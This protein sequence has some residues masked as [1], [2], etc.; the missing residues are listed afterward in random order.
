MTAFREMG[1]EDLSVAHRVEVNAFTGTARVAIP[2]TV[3]PGRE[4]FGPS[5]ELAYESGGASSPFG[6]GWTLGGVPAIGIDTRRRLPTYDGEDGYAFAGEPLVPYLREVG[7]AWRAEAE[8][9]GAY[10]V[11]RFR[12]RV[13][14]TFERFERWTERGSGRVHWRAR[15][16]DGVVSVFGLAEDGSTRIADPADPDRRVYQWL[17]EAQHDRLGNRIL[18]RYKPED[19]AGVDRALAYEARRSG[20]GLLPQRYLKAISYVNARP[21]A[22]GAAPD[23]TDVFRVEVVL[24]YGEHGAAGAPPS[25]AEARPWPVRADPYTVCTPGFELRSW[26]LCRRILVF[27]R[28]PELGPEPCLVAATELGHRED[29]AGAVL[30]SVVLRG[31]RKDLDSGA[32]DDRAL[33]PLSLSYSGAPPAA[34]FET[35]AP[36]RDPA[37]ALDGAA[38]RLVDL[39]GEG[40]PGILTRTGG[41]WYYRE[42]LGDGRFGPVEHAGEVPAAFSEAFGLADFDGDGNLD[43]VAFEGREAGFYARDRATGRWLGFRAFE[44]LPRVDLGSGRAQWVD[45]NGDGHADLVVDEGDRL[46]WYASEGADGFRPARALAKPDA[47]AGGAPA[48]TADAALGLLFADMNGDGLADLVRVEDGRIEYWPSLGGGRFGPGVLMEDAPLLGGFGRL[49]PTRVRLV[50][51]DGSGTAD[52]V[53]LGAG[54]V[55]WWTNESGNRFG[56]EHR[57]TGLPYLDGLSSAQ[58]VDLMGD[59]TLCLVWSSSLPG[60]V[61]SSYLRLGGPLPPRLLVSVSNGEGRRTNLAYRSSARDLLRDKAAGRGWH[62]LLPGHPTVVAALEAA[63]ELGGARLVTTYAYHDGVHDDRER[64]MTGFGLVERT[65]GDAPLD[66]GP[67]PA[68]RSPGSL[69]RTWFLTG[70]GDPRAARAREHWAGDPLAPHL[71]PPALEDLALL[72]A[73]EALEAEATLAASL[74]REEVYAVGTD[75][76]RAATPLTT[77]EATYG[78]R[79]LQ[80]ASGGRPAVFTHFQTESLSCEY[81][82]DPADPRV[83]HE[84]LLASS[85]YGDVE[86][87]VSI[88]YGRRAHGAEVR[89]EQRVL[90]AT[91]ADVRF[92][93]VDDADRYETGIEVDLR[94]HALRGLTPGA[95]GLLAREALR[96]EVTA[97]LAAPLGL[98]EVDP[99]GAPRARLVSWTRNVFWDAARA[100]PLPLGEVGPVTLLHHVERAVLADAEVAAAWGGRVDAALLV[101]GG[102]RLDGGTWWA[103]DAVKHHADGT[104]FFRLEEETTA[105]GGRQRFVFDDHALLVR[106]MEDAAGNQ[107]ESVLDYQVLA[108]TSVTDPNGNV[109]EVRYDPLGVAIVTATRGRQLGADDLEHPVG[110]QA[111]ATWALP[112]GATA[113]DVLADP[114][115]FLQAASTFRLDDVHAFARGEGPPRSILLERED[116]LDDGEGGA[117]RTASRIRVTVLYADGLGRTLQTK[118]RVD[119]G[120]AI[121][122][123]AAGAVALDAAGLPALAPAADRW[124]ASGHPVHDQRGWVVRSFEPFFTTTPAFEPD[125]ALRAFGVSARHTFDSAGR[126]V[127]HDL[128]DGTV[129]TI[130]YGPWRTVHS[131]ANDAVAGSAWEAARAALPAADPERRAL[132]GALAH[133]GTPVV[134][135]LDPRGRPIRVRELGA[136]GVERIT[137][138]EFGDQGL[139]VRAVDARG[140]DA[141][142][143]RHDMLGRVLLERGID[144]GERWVLADAAGSAVHVWDARGVHTRVSHDVAGRPLE[145]I[146]EEPGL[147]PRVVVR[148]AYGDGPGAPADAALRNARGRP[149]RVDDEAGVRYV[150]RY[151]LSGAE[152]DVRR[153]LRTEWTPVDWGAP[154]AVTLEAA[155]HRARTEHDGLGRIVRERLADGTTRAYRHA[156]AGHVAEVRVSTADGLLADVLLASEITT[157]A[158]GRRT[159]LLAGNGV[160]TSYAYD[161]RSAR[162]ARLRARRAAGPGPDLADVVYTYDPVGNVT[163][164]L[165]RAHD[166]AAPAPL[167]AGL[168][169]SAAC[170]YTYD[171]FYQLAT[172]TGRVHQA[173]LPADER[174]PGAP[175]SIKGTRHLTLANGAAIERYTRTYTYDLAG[176][177]RRIRHDGASRSWITEVWT[178]PTSNRSLPAEGA[179]G[180]AIPDPAAWFDA[181]GHV[182]RMPH[183]RALRWDH[184]GRLVGATIVDRS[185]AGGPDDA[186]TYVHDADGRRVRRITERLVAGEVERTDTVYL[187]GCELRR[188]TRAGNTRLLRFTSHL[189]DGASRLATLHQWSVDLGADDTADPAQ[190]RLVYLVGN[191]LGSTAL[192]LDGAGGVVTYEEYFP[193]GGTSFVAGDDLRDVRRKEYRHCGRLRDDATGFY[194]Y[195]FRDYAPWIGHW[196][197][198]DPL[199]PEDGLNLYAFVQGNPIRFVDADGLQARDAVGMKFDLPEKYVKL[200]RDPDPAAGRALEKAVEARLWDVPGYGRFALHGTIA[201]RKDVKEWWYTIES[202]TRVEVVDFEDEAV[203]PIVERPAGR[204]KTRTKKKKGAADDAAKER[205]AGTKADA[206]D[207]KKGTAHPADGSSGVGTTAAGATGESGS[208]GTATTGTAGGAGAKGAAAGGAGA[209][210]ASGTADLPEKTDPTKTGA[211]AAGGGRG[212]D[213]KGTDED[214]E[215]ETGKTEAAGDE[216]GA[217]GGHEKGGVGGV[218]GG[219]VGGVPNAPP[220]PPGY[221]TGANGVPWSPDL[222]PPDA[223]PQHGVPISDPRLLGGKDDRGAPGTDAPGVVRAGAKRGV[224]SP[225]GAGEQP[226]GGEGKGSGQKETALGTLTRLAGYLNFSKPGDDGVADGIPGGL[227]LLGLRGKA[228]QVLYVINT[229]VTTVLSIWS[230]V[231]SVS[232]SALRAGFTR[233]LTMIRNPGAALR[234]LWTAMRAFGGEARGAFSR[235]VTSFRDMRFMRPT[236]FLKQ[237]FRGA[238]NW[239]TTQAWRDHVSFL[240]KPRWFGKGP[241]YNWEHAVPQVLGRNSPRLAAA[242]NGYWNTFLRLPSSFNSSLGARLAP[243]VAF[244]VGA[245]EA[246]IRSFK[247]GWGIGEDATTLPEDEP[248]PAAAP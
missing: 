221:Q 101:D 149:V 189:G 228:I 90:D 163:R 210:E 16:G 218:A 87:Q 74:W 192:E 176:N 97:A 209:S 201:W 107:V 109:S 30:A 179:D 234:G 199:G 46:V 78:V 114:A 23:P 60:S 124:L 93:A 116:H 164:I 156:A 26:R 55:R 153:V 54:E 28:F 76:V 56:P 184:A 217:K 62:T 115:A 80:P 19:R 145:T 181:A 98:H 220:V 138:T 53:Y 141:F 83:T 125:A 58:I 194:H 45:L 178:S 106:A 2:V 146:V 133:A 137:A 38:H 31:Y 68:D 170:E 208:N 99:G 136:G 134:M 51:L 77:S 155:A 157:D 226:G 193:Y 132:D 177:L 27:H 67:P 121:A 123:D 215:D 169:A 200:V 241:F 160:E 33:P 36:S 186:E 12:A 239:K 43:L 233:L 195:E 230:I 13:E 8:A 151:A 7:G 9:R 22:P 39:R 29:R 103:D 180:V 198:P 11:E 172:A 59:G 244:Y 174:L 196:L 49:D 108:A 65:E 214:G 167:L 150:D 166:P 66:G 57:I 158:H 119:P 216:A 142:T 69:A 94:R 118:A 232:L 185:A 15:N 100:A 32:V 197:S 73:D 152:L 129:V 235:F 213:T 86:R 187:E 72:G 104:G 242:L 246:T 25:Y 37:P 204:G 112:A 247:L 168:T 236:E 89:P 219:V 70:P 84:V 248:Q 227:G 237:L 222:P 5:L 52:L 96:T 92:T 148:V 206:A 50:D 117:P 71:P 225:A 175:G 120:P 41:S 131:D 147:A 212:A 154:A 128:A 18:Y 188:V 127:R 35:L 191:H 183:L 105:R 3:S 159:R 245:L 79:R 229:V 144:A 88:A 205:G 82:S 44:D 243:K 135:D 21:R 140:L 113:A 14:R 130:A 139:A 75:G 240:F 202:A 85:P 10:Q 126:A 17:L 173:L 34:A 223:L 91:L 4:G 231:K 190:K 47:R 143:Y 224:G 42:N 48:L 182:A 238:R 64:R 211:G 24:D 165:D 122:R 20:G 61:A 95:D 6:L 63:D 1:L 203:E 207:E 162:L 110:A 171:P 81:G 161:P 111:L 40:V 102:Y